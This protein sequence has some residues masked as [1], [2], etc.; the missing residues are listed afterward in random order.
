M[1][2]R[3][4]SQKNLYF[5]RCPSIWLIQPK[6][7]PAEIGYWQGVNQALGFMAEDY[8]SASQSQCDK[9]CSDIVRFVQEW[10]KSAHRPT[11]LIVDELSL[12]KAVFPQWYTSRL[13]PQILA[14]MSS[15]E[16]DHRA[17]W[18][19]TQ[20]PLAR[21]IG[22]SG[23]N[24]APFDLV[25]IESKETGEHL[26]SIARSYAG[27]PLPSDDSLYALSESPKGTIIYHSALGDWVPMPRYAPWEPTANVPS[28]VQQPEPTRTLASGEGSDFGTQVRNVRNV[29]NPPEPSP[30][31]ISEP[32]PSLVDRVLTLR[33]EGLTQDQI[34]EVLWG[35]KKGG[36]PAY[37]RARDEYQFIIEAYGD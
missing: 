28:E 4:H 11:V 29:P 35:A 22:L 3:C 33:A 25:A 14:E 37:K 17:F 9:L 23:G 13:V 32:E 1:R 5:S 12:L 18:G 36:G 8:L 31:D 34:I 15:G 2:S 27:V 6:A 10:R 26:R 16:T 19:I 24:R 7:H 20:S 21:D 30:I